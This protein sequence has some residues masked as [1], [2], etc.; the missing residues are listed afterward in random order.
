MVSLDIV[1]WDQHWGRSIAEDVFPVWYAP[2]DHDGAHGHDCGCESDRGSD[3]RPHLAQH[4]RLFPVAA[5]LQHVTS[6]NPHLP[7]ADMRVAVA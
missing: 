6:A 1:E 5:R 4:Q 7:L 3:D 2:W